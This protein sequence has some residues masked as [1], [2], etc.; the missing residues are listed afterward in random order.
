M[1]NQLAFLKDKQR[2]LKIM[3]N[4]LLNIDRNDAITTPEVLWE[5]DFPLT[6]QDAI[7]SLKSYNHQLLKIDLSNV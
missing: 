7:D 1:E 4:N 5:M 6:K 2:M 3:F